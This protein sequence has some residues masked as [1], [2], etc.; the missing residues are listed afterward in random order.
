MVDVVVFLAS[1][2]VILGG[3]LGNLIDR[4][5]YLEVIDFLDFHLFFGYTWPTFNIADTAIVV[6][7]GILMVEIFFEEDLAEDPPLAETS[8]PSES[9][10][11]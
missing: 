3:A 2:A 8:R 5:V 6:G 7:V 4:I 10:S 1:A 11:T 9:G